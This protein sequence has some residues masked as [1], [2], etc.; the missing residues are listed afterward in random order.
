MKKHPASKFQK[1]IPV[2]YTAHSS[3]S[4]FMKHHICVFVL[5]KGY[6]P[7]NPF[8]NSEYFLIDVVPR[9]AIW[10]A[11]SSYI[12][13]CDEVWTFGDISDGVL[14]EVKLARK[15]SK[16]IKHFALGKKFQNIKQ[17]TKDKLDY[18]DGLE[19]ME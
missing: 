4:A 6:V 16:R 10:R 18:E 8:M 3:K 13:I 2:V 9:A 1:K 5:R 7:I 19:S 11:N 14:E 15:L 12:H 17:I